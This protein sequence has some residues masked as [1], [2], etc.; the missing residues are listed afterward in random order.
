MSFSSSP[1]LEPVPASKDP[2]R[3]LL[4]R[5]AAGASLQ[6]SN[7]LRELLEYLGDRTLSN[8]DTPIREQ[9]IGVAVFGRSVN[10]DTSQDTLVRVQAS[11]LRK[12][13]QQHFAEDGREEPLIIEIPKG[14]YSLSFHLRE[15]L[16]P[17]TAIPGWP[18]SYPAMAP[19]VRRGCSG[20]PKRRPALP[21]LSP[22][23]PD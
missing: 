10:Y 20:L 21:E 17:P 16:D 9:E 4:E 22:A 5:V 3:E 18:V 11:Q 2:R 13:L 8:P 23:S 12:K 1:R 15:A 7:R 19:M 14:S 6:K